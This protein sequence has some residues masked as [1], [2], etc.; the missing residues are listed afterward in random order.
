MC[1]Q[2]FLSTQFTF[3][4][5]SPS[6]QYRNRYNF[7][8]LSSYAQQEKVNVSWIFLEA[9]H[10]KSAADGIGA[11]IKRCA[12][13]TVKSG[14][15]VLCAKDVLNSACGTIKTWEVNYKVL[16]KF[17]NLLFIIFFDLSAD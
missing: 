16:R 4:S 8:L 1:L 6:G 12:D 10:G 3:I 5:D 17:K 15:D 13:D 7:H 2:I 9:G 11:C 14:G